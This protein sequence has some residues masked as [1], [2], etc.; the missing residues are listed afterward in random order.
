MAPTPRAAASDP[1]QASFLPL[2]DALAHGDVVP[3]EWT[4]TLGVQPSS[5]EDWVKGAFRVRS[6]DIM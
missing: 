3:P 1:M 6:N 2:F 5:L 4:A